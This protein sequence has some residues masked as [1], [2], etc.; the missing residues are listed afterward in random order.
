V[1]LANLA[2]VK[3]MLVVIVEQ[4]EFTHGQGVKELL[5]GTDVQPLVVLGRILVVTV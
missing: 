4:G 2:R 3:A 5:S 1:L